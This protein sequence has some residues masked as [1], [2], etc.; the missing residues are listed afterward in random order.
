M[1][2]GD[3]SAG[4]VEHV[5]QQPNQAVRRN[6]RE[7]PVPDPVDIAAVERLRG[8]PGDCSKNHGARR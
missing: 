2:Y 7:Q 5:T 8:T 1:P 4:L 3:S 6:Q